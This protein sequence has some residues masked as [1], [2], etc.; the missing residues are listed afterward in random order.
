MDTKNKE[1]VGR[2]GRTHIWTINAKLKILIERR[3]KI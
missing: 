3:I 2:V 1:R